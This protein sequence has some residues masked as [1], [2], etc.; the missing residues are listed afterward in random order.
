LAALHEPLARDPVRA[1]DFLS[2]CGLTIHFSD[3][4]GA[5]ISLFQD[6]SLCANAGEV[7]AILGRSGC[8][9]ST[10][11]NA[12]AGVLPPQTGKLAFRDQ[13][14]D[15][16]RAD[17]RISYLNQKAVLLP[18]LSVLEN[19]LEPARLAG[20]SLGDATALLTRLGLGDQLDAYPGTLSGGMYQRVALA[21][22]LFVD[23]ALLLMDEPFSALDEITRIK[24]HGTLREI[25]RERKICCLI[26]THDISESFVAADRCIVLR[27][28]PVA[29]ELDS[30]VTGLDESRDAHLLQLRSRILELMR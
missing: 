24:A 7:L 28:L 3:R 9:K 1:G 2:I 30:D 27:G 5:Q 13:S 8:G 25:V 29:V 18:W 10:L 16:M 20:R 12:L 6:F 22:A 15:Q 23:P 17:R 19:V 26:V 11:L 14:L 21:R 4:S